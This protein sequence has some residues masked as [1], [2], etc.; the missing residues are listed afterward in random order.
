MKTKKITWP[1]ILP[2]VAG[3]ITLPTVLAQQESTTEWI[4]DPGTPGNWNDSGA[5]SAGV[6]VADS[7]AGILNGGTADVTSATAMLKQLRVSGS[8][9]LNIGSSLEIK[10]TNQIINEPDP[11]TPATGFYVNEGAINVLSGGDFRVNT[12]GVFLLGVNASAS[13]NLFPGGSLT[14]DRVVNLG[15]GGTDGFGHLTISG[16][17]LIH[18][19]G[20]FQ[21]GPNNALGQLDVSGGMAVIN[22]LRV[23]HGGSDATQTNTVN[24]TGGDINLTGETAIGWDTV[25]SATYHLSE[26]TLTTSQRIR[27]GVSNKG[28][29]T[30][31][32][33]FNQTG[34]SLDVTG[35]IDIGDGSPPEVVNMLEI[36]GGSL[37]ASERML[38]G[39][40]GSA[41]GIFKL[42]GTAIIDL[43]GMFIGNNATNTGTV[44][45]EDEAGG[46]ITELEVR[47][48]S[49]TQ[50]SELS[51]IRVRGRLWVGGSQTVSNTA[52][53]NLEEGALE[54]P[55]GD[56][57]GN[58]NAG[59]ATMNIMGGS[60]TSF[61]RL[62]VGNGAANGS[63]TPTNRVDQTGGNVTIFGR[64]DLGQNPGPTNIYRISGGRLDTTGNV[65][66]GFISD[67]TG[68]FIV[69]GDAEV[70]VL[71]V[72]MG[73]NAGT[74]LTGTKGTVQLLG[75]VLTTGQI[76]VGNGAP[77]DQT[78]IL[79]GGTIR[80]RTGGTTLIAGNVTTTS[81]L[82]GGI[83]FDTDGL[84]VST[85]GVMTGPGGLTK[86][87]AGTLTVTG[88]QAYTGATRAEQGTL[89]LAEP[90][91]SDNGDV[92]LTTGA[93]LDLQHAT[94]DTIGTLFVDGVAQAGGTYGGS[95]SGA[96]TELD[97]L[98][99]G[100]GVL[101]SVPSTTPGEAPVIS[102]IT[103]AAGVA[104]IVISGDPNTSYSCR[105]SNDL[106]TPFALVATN[107]ES[108]TTDGN[109]EVT[110][111]VDASV[112]TRFYVVGAAE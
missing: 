84:D 87:G 58:G 12:A 48:G 82:A 18:T 88:V 22:N 78:L 13:L 24:Q 59:D 64:L 53:F 91:L 75:G 6:P 45:V 43:P 1:F 103:V 9:T 37:F 98:I 102:S 40:R 97:G 31:I 99:S 62:R 32:N 19:G 74:N 61:N 60:L 23:N 111:T 7:L 10:G 100:T 8:S 36:S 93:V 47:N 77:G 63:L 68:T 73:E 21:V 70:D 27:I 3:S 85:A 34:G 96:D 109:G 108:V 35:R 86:T 104:T 17:D 39:A 54:L 67:G 65:L 95:G 28:D 29:A 5:W 4:I 50:S 92:Y 110:F 33:T 26:G 107:P 106:E 81:L 14:T 101:N 16:G 76:R 105:F 72:V 44:T 69:D 55:G 11:P 2:L 49:Y 51:S 89:V 25:G 46:E 15:N 41:S 20:S 80:A 30:R 38:V 94:T 112:D 90:Y 52:T 57:V 56:I 42:G 83:T 66:V 71:A 79:D